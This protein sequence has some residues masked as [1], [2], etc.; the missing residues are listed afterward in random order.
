MGQAALP[1][2]REGLMRLVVQRAGTLVL[3]VLG[4]NPPYSELI[5]AYFRGCIAGSPCIRLW[6]PWCP[7]LSAWP[8]GGELRKGMVGN[9]GGSLRRQ[10]GWTLCTE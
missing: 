1:M 6:S 2:P 10:T 7:G 8:R 3:P 9:D 4:T 5:L